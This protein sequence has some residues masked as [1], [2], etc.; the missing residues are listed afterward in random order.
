MKKKYVVFLLIGLMA[1][2]VSF[3]YAKKT[4]LSLWCLGFEPHKLGFESVVKGFNKYYPDIRIKVEP[5][6]DLSTK[7]KAALAARQAP[8]L[9][10]PRA[11][12][13]M[14]MVYTKSIAPFPDNVLT[15]KELKEKFWPEYYL[16]APFNK[17]YAV[18]FPDP[19][20]DAGLVVNLDMFKEAGLKQIPAFE[21][22]D[23]LIKYAKKLTKVDA[24]GNIIRGGLNARE[25]NIQ[26]YFWGYIADQGGRF[27]D[28]DTGLFNYKT[29]E[30][31]KALK[32]F[33]DIYYTYKVDSVDLPPMF[34]ALAQG[35]AAMGF[36]WGEYIS[37]AHLTY[38]ELHFGFV[39]KPPFVKGVKPHI[40]HV[41]T[42]NVSVWEGSKNKDA[43]FKFVKYMT[44]PE[45]QL[46][47][48]QQNPGIPALRELG[49]PKYFQSEKLRFLIPLLK[50]LPETK[51]WGPFGNDSIIKDSLQRTM[52]SVMHKEI[53]V[54]EALDEMTRQCNEAVKTFRKKYPNAP[55]TK[56]E[57]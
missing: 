44:T 4:E 33:Y 12:D 31:R 29:E 47:F 7:I 26:V 14:E 54:K 30:A 5:Q 56:I 22:I 43:A 20:G 45:A 53:S 24:K 1:I 57:W 51:F 21:S 19:L 8:D 37:F 55:I 46:L 28:N 34:D 15:V 6:A 17:V 13:I 35:A 40:A 39:L 18:G 38:P 52:E 2:S 16:Q 11:E 49:N 25:Y 23:Q 48:L 9:F 3:A 27:Y 42:W 10:T 32:F 36:M 50:L 41:D